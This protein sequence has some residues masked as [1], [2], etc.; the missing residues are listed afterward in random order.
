M[1]V[2]YNA[3]IHEIVHKIFI[4][5]FGV[6]YE[7]DIFLTGVH[8]IQLPKLFNMLQMYIYMLKCKN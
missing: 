6:K 5:Y 8:D 3:E 1:I 4:S 2:M 7:P